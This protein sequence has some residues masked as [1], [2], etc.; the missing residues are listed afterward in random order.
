MT[1]I[2]YGTDLRRKIIQFVI[3]AFVGLVIFQLFRMQV[4]EYEVYTERSRSN[5]IKALKLNSPRGVFYDRNMKVLV[6]NMPTYTIQIT[7]S[8]YSDSLNVILENVIGID[9][10][11]IA[12]ILYQKRLYSEFLPRSIKKD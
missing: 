8:Y 6:S 11:R 5:S 1:D 2:E 10:G 9:S 12:D 7:P 4:I 3:V